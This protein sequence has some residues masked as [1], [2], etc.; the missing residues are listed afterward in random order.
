MTEK[1][2]V[3]CGECLAQEGEYH[4][5][6]CPAKPNAIIG[7]RLEEECE[8]AYKKS[9][10]AVSKAIRKAKDGDAV[11][12][13]SAMSTDEVRT[14]ASGATRHIDDDK[15]D[16][17][18]FLSPW[19]IRRYG[20]YMHEHRVQADGTLRDSDN[21]QKGIPIDEYMKSLLRHTLDTHAVHRGLPSFD[22][23]DSSEVEIEDLLC[24]V[25]FNAYG[26]L[27]EI[28]K[29]RSYV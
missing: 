19:V 7:G 5:D 13:P 27:H 4:A 12:I 14:F 15:Y 8:D 6:W 16:Y 9:Y 25:I 1:K 23:K 20:E 22:M 2:K 29:R 24:A 26:Y 28:L 21:W 17:E 11:P 18:G 3:E 10:K